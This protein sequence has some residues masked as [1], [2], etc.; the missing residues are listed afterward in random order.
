MSDA[1][2]EP[3]DSQRVS[4]PSGREIEV[5]Y[6]TRADDLPVEP[7]LAV[8][9]S[10]GCGLLQPVTWREADDDLLELE[11]VCPNCRWAGRGIFD[12]EAVERFEESLDDGW[13]AISRDLRRLVQADMENEVE[14]FVSALQADAI[15]PM[16]F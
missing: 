5:V 14:R 2:P 9:P 3:H 11:R 1:L 4:L 8:C 15:L 10:C 6:Y 7:D 13:A 16:D 12:R